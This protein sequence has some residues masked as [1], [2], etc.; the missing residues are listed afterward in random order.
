MDQLALDSCEP[1]TV[2]KITTYPMYRLP[3]DHALYQADVWIFPEAMSR[4]QNR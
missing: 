2:L 3:C 1:L 4:F